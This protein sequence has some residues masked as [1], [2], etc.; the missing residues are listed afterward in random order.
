MAIIV[1]DLQSDLSAD[2][3]DVSAGV[4]LNGVPRRLTFRR[5]G[6]HPGLHDRTDT[7]APTRST[8]SPWP[9]SS[10]P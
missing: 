4:V 1:R 3:F 5:F 9:C 8:R 10:R 7:I 6:N 2:T